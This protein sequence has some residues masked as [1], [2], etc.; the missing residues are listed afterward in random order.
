[1][2]DLHELLYGKA[3][4]NQ[5]I[6]PKM[7]EKKEKQMNDFIEAHG[8]AP[9]QRSDEWFLMRNN[10][11]GASELAAIVGM[12]PYQNF[13]GLARKKR[14]K[15]NS[16]YSNLSCWWSTIFE[17]V[18]VK[19]AESELSTK[20]RGTNIWV[21]LPEDSQLHGKHVV[22]PDGYSIVDF[23]EQD[24]GW[25]IVRK[26]EKVKSC[27]RLVPR[28]ALFE[29]KCPHRRHPKGFVP[30]YYLPQVWAGLE[31]SPF[32]NV[33]VF[34]EMVIRKCPKYKVEKWGEYERDYHFN[35]K[36]G[37]ELARAVSAVFRTEKSEKII[38][39]GATSKI[40][41]DNMMSEAVDGKECRIV[42]SQLYETDYKR[43]EGGNGFFMT[44]FFYW[45]IFRFNAHIVKK[46]PGFMERCTPLIIECLK[47]ST[48]PLHV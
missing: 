19:Y 11:I 46:N 14:S 28:A 39:Y 20:I 10:V 33:G 31:I 15:S 43:L 41:F 18:A 16:T 29:F 22:S 25:Y 48:Q 2:R 45:K 23:V 44:G 5:K 27:G 21:K 13:D 8:S 26:S 24:T 32:A 30:R 4:E 35:Y 7:R 17:D 6:Y 1:M 47:Q 37:R 12:S 3:E 42:H 38:D 9:L 36:W 34:C 40:D